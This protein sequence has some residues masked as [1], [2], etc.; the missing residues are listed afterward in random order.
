MLDQIVVLIVFK[1]N[2]SNWRSEH[3]VHVDGGSNDVL[4]QVSFGIGTKCPGKNVQG[5][6]NQG[7]VDMISN[8]LFLIE[9]NVV[10]TV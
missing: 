7:Q 9:K 5:W 2:S 10:L 8:T 6:I 1:N 3:K 4:R